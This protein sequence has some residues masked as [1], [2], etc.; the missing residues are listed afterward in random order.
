[1]TNNTCSVC[2]ERSVTSARDAAGYVHH[3]C[4]SHAKY[5][6]GWLLDVEHEIHCESAE[7]RRYEEWAH[8]ED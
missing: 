3:A 5:I 8:G 7:A 1:M 6:P 4:R 2:S